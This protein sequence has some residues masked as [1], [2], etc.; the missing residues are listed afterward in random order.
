MAV[1][2]SKY[3]PLP[4]YS[5]GD[6][7]RAGAELRRYW[8]DDDDDP[9]DATVEAFEAMIAFRESFQMPLKQDG[10]GAALDGL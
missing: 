4:G 9:T 7:I 10:D 6:I 8:Q 1:A 2:T 3:A 5:R